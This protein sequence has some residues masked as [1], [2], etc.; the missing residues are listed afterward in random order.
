MLSLHDDLRDVGW[1]ATLSVDQ[2]RVPG[3]K[4]RKKHQTLDVW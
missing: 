1:A 4:Q 2:F 3:K